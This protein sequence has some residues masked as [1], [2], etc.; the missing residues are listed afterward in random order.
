MELPLGYR[1]WRLD[2]QIKY[3]LEKAGVIPYED[4]YFDEAARLIEKHKNPTEKAEFTKI[5]DDIKHKK[6]L[7]STGKEFSKKAKNIEVEI[8]EWT[9]SGETKKSLQKKSFE[10]VSL[11]L[12]EAKD[13]KEKLESNQSAFNATGSADSTFSTASVDSKIEYL[14]D[15]LKTSEHKKAYPDVYIGS[16]KSRTRKNTRKHSSKKDT[17]KTGKTRKHSSKKRT[18]KTRRH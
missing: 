5:L 2:R 17:K 14:T 12:K 6:Y 3:Q 15:L 9:S 16:R 1:F 7:Y 11:L 13:E 8:E 10:D 4:V 18:K